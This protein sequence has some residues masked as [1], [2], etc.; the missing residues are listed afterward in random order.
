MT[1]RLQHLLLVSF[2]CR[3]W[4]NARS[5]VADL[6]V[7]YDI[8]LIQ[9]HWLFSDHLNQLN[10]N[11]DFLSVGVS[12]MESS[13]LLCGRPFGGCAICFRKLL[14]SSVTMLSTNA[15]RFCAISLSD[16]SGYTVL[17]ICVYLPT[18]YD[19]LSSRDDF[20]YVTGELEGFVISQ[21]FD[22]LLIVGDFNVD[23]D[24]SSPIAH[25]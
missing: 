24:R 6:P 20:L 21:S 7:S 11:P 15:K 17:L 19:T 10:F 2:N 14:I 16:Q 5:T 22:R 12:G 1:L 4:Y 9:E 8:C 25:N 13:I 23:F 18:E 3:D